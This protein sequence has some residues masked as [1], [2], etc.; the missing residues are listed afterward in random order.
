MFKA[1]IPDGETIFTTMSQLAHEHN[2]INLGQ[3]FPDYD[4][5][6][7]LIDLVSNAMNRGFNQYAHA[8]GYLPL[9]ESIAQKTKSLYHLDINSQKEICVTP[10]ATYAIFTALTTVLQPGDEV[11]VFEPTYDS[12]IPNIL[13]N[14][15]KPIII[16]LRYPDFRIDWDEVR[17]AVT[18]RTKMIM[19]NSPHNPTSSV[20]SKEDMKQLASIV[21]EFDLYVLSDEVYEP[22]IFDGLKHESVLRYPEI[23]QKSF[24]V[25]SFGKA[26]HCTGWKTGYCIAP[27]NLMKEFIKVHQFN[28]FSCF[29]PVQV[30]LAEYM[31]DEKVFSGLSKFYQDKRDLLTEQLTAAGFKALPSHGSFFRLFDYSELSEED[32]LSF[33]KKITTQAGVGAIPL[34]PFYSNRPPFR[35]LRFCFAKKDETLLTA[36]ERLKKFFKN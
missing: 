29:S 4:P 14:G 11:I 10:G 21:K 23:F 15:A 7:K 31:K 32:D 3:G 35:A 26:Y 30:A 13:T 36:G 19:I 25:F 12:Y 5:D 17:N 1:K 16:P 18:P 6:S 22:I 8:V 34:S 20:L 2:A 33:A 27:Q 9:R 24:A 28:A